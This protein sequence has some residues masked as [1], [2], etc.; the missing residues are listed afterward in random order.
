MKKILKFI[1]AL[2]LIPNLIY[3]SNINKRI[4]LD[5]NLI[6]IEDRFYNDDFA[7]M[8]DEEM[9]KNYGTDYKDYLKSNFLASE[10]AHNINEIFKKENNKYFFPNFFGGVYISENNEVILQTVE[11]NE[12]NN[13]ILTFKEKLTTLK[14]DYEEE[15]VK[16]SFNELNDTYD[17]ILNCYSKNPKIFANILSFYIDSKN[18]YV[19]VEL[20]EF[21]EVKI[22]EFKQKIIDSPVVFL[23]QGELI[24][25]YKNLNPGA[26]WTT[27]SGG[28]C[29]FG[30]RA[31]LGVGGR[32]GIV[33]AGHCVS[34]GIGTVING[35]GTVAKRKV[36]GN[37]DA[38]WIETTSTSNV[39]TNNFN[40]SYSLP[41][42]L[43]SKNVLTSFITGQI[44]AKI[45]YS[46]GFT[47]GKV[48]STNYSTSGLTGLIKTDFWAQEGDSG[49]I[50]FKYPD[51]AVGGGYSTAGIVNGGPKGGGA[52]HF[53]RA[54]K[55]NS[56]FALKRY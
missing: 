56:E 1:L 16:Y 24:S 13:L 42:S 14:I 17:Y 4:V 51:T 33:S 19:V 27:P 7:K 12:L 36:G 55:I 23:K 29:S 8:I 18:N 25:N 45:G 39:P 20:K 34:N 37:I 53:V 2:S 47:T 5:D 11:S 3:A 21:S 15:K 31:Q 28:S 40:S 52:F 43:I 22:N 49:G 44:L 30:Y 26:V 54:D 35:I 41:S 32:K 46:S 9:K 10:K 50:V 6:L 48:T 38:A